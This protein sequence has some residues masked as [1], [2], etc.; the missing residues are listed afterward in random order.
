MSKPAR[1]FAA[2]LACLAWVTL[3]HYVQIGLDRRPHWALWQELWRT[4]RYFTFLTNTLTALT[5]TWIA[6]GG[7]ISSVWVTGLTLWMAIVAVVYHTLLA[8]DYTGLRWWTDQGLHTAIPL[9]LVLWWG[10]FA[11][12]AGLAW[13]HAAMWLGWPGLYM[14][15]ALIRGEI[16]GRHPYFFIDPP[17]IGWPKVGMWIGLLGLVFWLAGLCVVA[18]GRA[19]SRDRVRPADDGPADPRP[20]SPRDPGQSRVGG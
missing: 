20:R 11:P 3:Y 6:L 19:L 10:V 14:G 9:A 2:L 1:L 7:R 17:L 15:Y 12:K 5:A 16:D 18:L 13:R 8:R 4:G